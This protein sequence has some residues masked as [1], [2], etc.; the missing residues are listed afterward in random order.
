[1]RLAGTTYVLLA[2]GAACRRETLASA[3]KEP[4]VVV[5][6]GA[7]RALTLDSVTFVARIRSDIAAQLKKVDSPGDPREGV[8]HIV[9]WQWVADLGEIDLWTKACETRNLTCTIMVHGSG[10]MVFSV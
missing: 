10:T 5:S 7:T 2:C 1:M 6:A 3:A 8:P 4:V 9:G